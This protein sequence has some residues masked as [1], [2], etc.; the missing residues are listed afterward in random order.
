MEGLDLDFGEIHGVVVVGLHGVVVFLIVL[1]AGAVHVLFHVFPLL[2]LVAE[3][4]EQFVVAV[5]L[6]SREILGIEFHL[7]DGSSERLEGVVLR[8]LYLLEVFYETVSV[9]L[10]E[11]L[12]HL[13]FSKGVGV[14]HGVV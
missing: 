2:A 3:V 13:S 7:N 10:S 5:L 6:L 14:E 4:G 11:F 8:D 9:L 12:D 1:H